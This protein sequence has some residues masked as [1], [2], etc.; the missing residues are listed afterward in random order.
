MK[1][2]FVVLAVCMIASVCVGQ[3]GPQFPTTIPYTYVDT[4]STAWIKV[5]LNRLARQPFEA[6]ALNY[7]SGKLYIALRSADTA[8]IGI[9]KTDSLV[10]ILEL[11]AGTATAPVAFHWNNLSVQSFFIR[12]SAAGTIC[13]FHFW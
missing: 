10:R 4:V 6:E 11:D 3:D 9:A 1:G 12:A 2:L 5:T 8:S 7:G 13:R